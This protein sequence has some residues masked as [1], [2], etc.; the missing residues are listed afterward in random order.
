MALVK[1]KNIAEFTSIVVI[2]LFSGAIVVFVLDNLVGT[3]LPPLL[4]MGTH[5]S[6]FDIALT[7]PV[8][9]LLYCLFLNLK[10]KCPGF[11]GDGRHN[12]AI[13][14]NTKIS[15]NGNIQ[16]VSI[17]KHPL[18]A[19]DQS[20]A[21]VNNDLEESKELDEF[22]ISWGGDSEH[23]GIYKSWPQFAKSLATLI[24]NTR[25]QIISLPEFSNISAQHLKNVISQ[26]EDA[27]FEL[28]KGL[29]NI[30][31][32][33]DSFN[34]FIQKAAEN[35]YEMSSQS[36]EDREKAN[37]TIENVSNAVEKILEHIER[38]RRNNEQLE[39][40]VAQVII[41]TE[42]I[43][44]IAKQTNIL[45]LNTSIEATRAGDNGHGFEVIASE[46]RSLSNAVRHTA[47][48]IGVTADKLGESLKKISEDKQKVREQEKEISEFKNVV[49]S[50]VTGYA[51][52][53]D[54]VSGVVE[55]SLRHSVN[56]RDAIVSTLGGIQFQDIVRQQL[57]GVI[58][59]LNMASTEEQAL[60]SKL[61]DISTEQEF[62]D[63]NLAN[64][65]V[66]MKEKYVMM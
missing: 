31:V 47:Q 20:G 65:V 54:Y 59:A 32:L 12:R 9:F 15:T 5:V 28:I 63:C 21:T 34:G 33:T 1:Y 18:D 13:W 41:K 29:Q 56:M 51:S 40:M 35:S 14:N 46:A 45:A 26:T 37:I 23:N 55:E 25:N 48:E 52:M 36:K 6:A 38:D 58:D 53:S 8:A 66:S 30:E 27:S 64:V 50:L 24:K 44:K 3:R 62:S 42:L 16:S 22:I 39:S 19:A 57:E 2:F 7:I 61:D 60:I 11:K 49:E 10:I 43:D 17:T 4:S